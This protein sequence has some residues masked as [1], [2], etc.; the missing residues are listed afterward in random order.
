MAKKE[1][2][3]PSAAAIIT[4]AFVSVLL[5]LT[6][7]VVNLTATAV[8]EV[9]ELPNEEE[10]DT[11]AVYF[12]KGSERRGSAWKN[13]RSALA[14]GRKGTVSVSEGEL[15][16]WAR[17]SFKP[18]PRDE[19]EHGSTLLGIRVVPSTPNFKIEE[20]TLQIA[21]DLQIQIPL[22]GSRSFA[23]QVKGSFKDKGGVQV[24]VPSKSYIGSCPI[25]LLSGFFFN[26]LAGS[27][28]EHDEYA[29]LNPSWAKLGSLTLKKE[30]LTLTIP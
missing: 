1:E 6:G 26:F 22:V 15:N 23:Y 10:V 12:V 2:Y 8:T 29:A 11:T 21:S 27:F 18:N 16:A 20:D 30:E 24:F 25:P 14:G 3:S 19:K 4:A 7:A 17:T 13:K 9:P 28:Y 5:G